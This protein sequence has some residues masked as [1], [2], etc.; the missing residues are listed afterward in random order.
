LIEP[1]VEVHE[2]KGVTRASQAVAGWPSVR[3]FL[4]KHPNLLHQDAALLSEL[5]LKL[6][7]ANVREFGPAA[8][9]RA[10]EAQRRETAVREALEATARANFAAQAQ[11]HTA[12]LDLMEARGAPD[13]ARRLDAAARDRLGLV[14]GALAVEGRAPTSWMQLEPGTVDLVLGEGAPARLGEVAQGDLLFPGAAQPV[15]SCALVRLTL[16]RPARPGLLAFGAADAQAFAPEMG[17]ELI[18]FIARVVECTAERWP[19]T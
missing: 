10:I 14:A 16:G 8:L 1:G 3:A 19:M 9:A 11:C 5:G 2:P 7:A 6:S 12:V 18:A 15:R 13:L 4:R 17:A